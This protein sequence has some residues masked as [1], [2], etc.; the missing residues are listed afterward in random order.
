MRLASVLF[1]EQDPG[2]RGLYAR[3]AGALERSAA[4]NSPRTP[5]TVYRHRARFDRLDSIRGDSPESGRRGLIDNAQ[6]ISSWRRI[7]ETADLGEV[8]GIMDCDTLVLGD[9]SAVL[10]IDFE[11]AYTARPP[12]ARLPFNAG[13]VFVRVSAA[14]R[15]FFAAWEEQNLRLLGDRTAHRP[16]R[17]KYGGINQAALGY[18]LERPVDV[19]PVAIPCTTWNCEDTSWSEFGPETKILHIKGRLRSACVRGRNPE[20]DIER[21]A[22]IWR[23]FDPCAS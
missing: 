8:L 4:A 17:N 11:V 16:L 9:L 12:W 5:L 3:L 13:V 6:K 21:L 14:T 20:P 1:R 22:E 2:P 19:V 10:E 15:R 7:V 18:L 23:R